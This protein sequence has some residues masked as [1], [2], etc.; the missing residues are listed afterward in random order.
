MSKLI[1]VKGGPTMVPFIKTIR[2]AIYKD[3]GRFG[4]FCFGD[5]DFGEFHAR[6]RE[7][8]GV[9]QMRHCYDGIIPVKMRFAKEYKNHA[10]GNR[11]IG[12]NK[13]AAGMAAW[14]ALTAEEKKVYNDIA[15]KRR[16]N[17][18]SIFMKKY[19]LS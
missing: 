11:S 9:Y 18:R 10:V 3:T 19:M 13:F 5:Y 8:D 12:R 4:L 7:L 2:E 6:G 15:T 17:G 14:G 1:R 16:T